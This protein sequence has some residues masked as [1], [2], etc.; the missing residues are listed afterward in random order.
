[1]LYLTHAIPSCCL[2]LGHSQLRMRIGKAETRSFASGGII[3]H[4]SLLRNAL[5]SIWNSA[6]VPATDE[7]P[8]ELKIVSLYCDCLARSTSCP[9]S[10]P[11]SYCRTPGNAA[12]CLAGSSLESIADPSILTKSMDRTRAEQSR[13]PWRID[14]ALVIETRMA[15]ALIGWSVEDHPFG[16]AMRP[17]GALQ[18]SPHWTKE[19]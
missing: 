12:C 3:S 5:V 10:S 11:T 13:V 8:A 16:N 2:V 6:Y 14:I 1:M 7:N 4:E 15:S 17:Q 19:G 18:L 9:A